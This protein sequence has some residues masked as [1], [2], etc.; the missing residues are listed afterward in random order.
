MYIDLVHCM[1][2]EAINKI[3]EISEPVVAQQD[4][5]L[6]DVEV[7]HQKVPEVWLFVDSEQQDVKLDECSRISKQVSR[8]L[9]HEDLFGGKYRLNV[10]SPGLSR[11]LSD[12]R[13]YAKNKGREIR[14]KYKQEGD[15]KSVTGTLEQV[16]SD[17][18]TL[19]Q[20]DEKDVEVLF[21]DIVESKVVPKI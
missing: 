6:V 10:S 19:L 21:D 4:M 7:K 17:R 20:E 15:Y 5:F 16:S 11:P 14:V 13:Q 9:D 8:L 12:K 3:K 1:Q 18:I 2:D